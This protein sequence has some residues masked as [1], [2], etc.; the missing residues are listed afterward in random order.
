AGGTVRAAPFP[1]PHTP[2]SEN[3]IPAPPTCGRIPPSPHPSEIMTSGWCGG[4]GGP[5]E[6]S[7]GGA[8]GAGGGRRAT[9]RH[10]ALPAPPRRPGEAEPQLFADYPLRGDSLAGAASPWGGGGRTRAQSGRHGR[11]G[12]FRTPC[13]N[14]LPSPDIAMRG[15]AAPLQGRTRMQF[16][17]MLY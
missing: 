3:L 5:W 12:V 1:P 8:G 14:H 6:A 17:L 15:Y 9:I 4:A 13:R 2:H 7:R 10:F 11:A 16:L